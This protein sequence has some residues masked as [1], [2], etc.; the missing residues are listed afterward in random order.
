MDFQL[1]QNSFTGDLVTPEDQEY[2]AAISRWAINS[3]RRAKIVA[4]VKSP[5]DVSL[6]LDYARRTNLQVAIRGG[7]H[8][9]SGSSSSDGGLVIDMSRHMCH[10]KVDPEQGVVYVGGGAT[11]EVVDKSAILH[12]LATPGGTVNHTGVGGLTLGGGYGWLSSAFGLALDNLIQ[13]TVVVADGSILT[14]NKDENSDL[15]WGIRGGGSNFGVCTEFVLRLHPQRRRV[16]AGTLVFKPDVLEPLLSLTEKWWAKEPCEK[17]GMVHVMTRGPDGQPCVVVFL[18]Y[19]GSEPEG[20]ATFKAVFDLK[21][22]VDTTCE[23]P[24]EEVN[25]L[26]NAA[27]PHGRAAYMK[28]VYQTKPRVDVILQAFDRMV[29]LSETR[30]LEVAILI[31]Y[32]PLGKITEVTNDATAFRRVRAG[33]VLSLVY[34]DEDTPDNQQRARDIAW[35][36]SNIVVKGQ[37]DLSEVDNTGYGNYDSDKVIL[38]GSQRTERTAVGGKARALFG[39]NYPRLQAI[40]KRYDPDL[41][42]SSWF[43]IIPSA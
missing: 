4:F 25:T 17:E 24:Y 22:L 32:F 19:N 39:E 5:E 18:F 37:H 12:G 43:P 1:F 23:M 10:A 31:E 21:P 42:F 34:W 13:A 28:G 7:G 11:W 9:P 26:Q 8:S 27:A 38:T 2:A 30:D 16:F 15:F 41:T 29:A 35:E 36:L 14:A 6:A 40:K 3:Q 20:R 33:N